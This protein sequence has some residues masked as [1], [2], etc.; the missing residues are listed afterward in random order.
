MKGAWRSPRLPVSMAF[1]ASTAQAAA[2]RDVSGILGCRL[3]EDTPPAPP[4]CMSSSGFPAVFLIQ[5]TWIQ[6][7]PGPL[8]SSKFYFSA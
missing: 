3:V 8:V 6:G 5:L 4:T 2:V 7:H 1:S